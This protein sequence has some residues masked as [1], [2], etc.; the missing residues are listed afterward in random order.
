MKS[1]RVSYFWSDLR[2]FVSSPVVP[3][4]APQTSESVVLYFPF[5]WRRSTGRGYIPFAVYYNSYSVNASRIYAGDVVS[6]KRK[7]FTVEI[8]HIALPHG[9][10]QQ[11][12]ALYRRMKTYP[13]AFW[14]RF[15]CVCACSIC[16]PFSQF[17]YAQRVPLC[18]FVKYCNSFCFHHHFTTYHACL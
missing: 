16:S 14:I 6:E 11:F 8:I 12:V 2:L 17:D 10:P 9:F 13:I 7:T 5:I 3:H 4:Y 18:L 1:L 15:C